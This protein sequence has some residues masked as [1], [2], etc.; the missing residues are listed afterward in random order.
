[1]SHRPKAR[2]RSLA[3]GLGQR[4][5]NALG[6]STQWR[7]PVTF[8]TPPSKHQRILAFIRAHPEQ[9]YNALTFYRWTDR[10][11]PMHP[12]WPRLVT[13]AM[14]LGV[15]VCWLGFGM[16]ALQEI[17]ALIRFKARLA[18]PPS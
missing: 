2:Y 6:D 15:P 7:R 11:R 9:Q 4:L 16:T 8:S 10:T 12:Q 17:D 1:M 3:P 5:E 13:L 18:P 14:D